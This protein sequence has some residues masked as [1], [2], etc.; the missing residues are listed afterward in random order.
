M[1]NWTAMIIGTLAA[2]ALIGGCSGNNANMLLFDQNTVGSEPGPGANANVATSTELIPGLPKG[3][4][5]PFV[6]NGFDPVGSIYRIDAS[7]TYFRVADLSQDKRVR[8]NIKNNVRIGNYAFND[9]QKA[10]AQMSVSLLKRV[11]P[12]LSGDA[13]SNTS[14]DI[15]IT[16]KNMHA[17]VLYDAEADY[18]RDWFAKSH[19]QRQGNRYFLVREAIFAGS[20]NYALNAKDLKTAGI[21]AKVEQVVDSTANAT[22]TDRGRNLVIEQTFDPPTQVCI[23]VAE[24]EIGNTQ[25]DGVITT[26]LKPTNRTSLPLIKR[27]GD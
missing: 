11:L 4:Q 13:K 17:K 12:G 9:T 27:I 14:F 25:P 1:R 2:A 15:G 22:F 24:I 23:K 19:R 16:V 21:K 18:I 26:A 6:P 10:S 7:G 5:C 20:V 8:Q 3:F